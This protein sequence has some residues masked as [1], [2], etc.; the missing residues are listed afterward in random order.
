MFD[1]LKILILLSLFPGLDLDR[2][3]DIGLEALPG[4]DPKVMGTHFII[5]S[6]IIIDYNMGFWG[7]G[8]VWR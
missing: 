6:K 7:F 1:S 8:G 4:I 3:L 5:L 2:V